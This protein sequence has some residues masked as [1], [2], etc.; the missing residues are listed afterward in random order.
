MKRMQHWLLNGDSSHMCGNQPSAFLSVVAMPHGNLA[1]WV[2]G[3]TLP[4]RLPFL[5]VGPIVISAHLKG[6]RVSPPDKSHWR[7]HAGGHTKKMIVG[8]NMQIVNDNQKKY[9]VAV[10]LSLQTNSNIIQNHAEQN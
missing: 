6:M 7:F 9:E 3:S 8:V 4:P 10:C 1:R 2:I 5:A